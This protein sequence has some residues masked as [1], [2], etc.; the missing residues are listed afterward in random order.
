MISLL[1]VK[2][3]ISRCEQFVKIEG[4]VFLDKAVFN[5]LVILN[6]GHHYVAFLGDQ[7]LTQLFQLIDSKLIMALY[8]LPIIDWIGDISNS[9][10]NLNSS[11]PFIAAVGFAMLLNLI[12][13]PM[14]SGMLKIRNF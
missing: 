7:T 1:S 3:Q 12:I 2:N 13:F 6:V 9:I 14:F 8:L 10:L 4:Y 11:S 5:I